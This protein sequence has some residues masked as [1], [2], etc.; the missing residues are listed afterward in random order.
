MS[1]TVATEAAARGSAAPPAPTATQL[2]LLLLSAILARLPADARARSACVARA[3]RDAAANPDAWTEVDLTRAGGLTCRKLDP[4]PI[5]T[6]LAPRL[7]KLRALRLH[8]LASRVGGLHINA[9]SFVFQNALRDVLELVRGGFLPA[10]R[11]LRVGTHGEYEQT[12]RALLAEAPAL[13]LL[14]LSELACD[15]GGIL[16]M[17]SLPRLRVRGVQ[18]L[19]RQRVPAATCEAVLGALERHESLRALGVHNAFNAAANP[20]CSADTCRRPSLGAPLYST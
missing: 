15:S 13:E 6:A 2:P 5:I 14:E 19:A 3:W 18:W 20:A 10:L 9:P 12:L 7:S 11:E 8:P 1:T 17:L 16:E 4:R